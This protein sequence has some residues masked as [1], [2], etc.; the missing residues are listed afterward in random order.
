MEI[1]TPFLAQPRQS[2]CFQAIQRCFMSALMMLLFAFISGMLQTPNNTIPQNELNSYVI[3]RTPF[4][5]ILIDVRK[6]GEIHAV[7]GSKTQTFD[8]G[9]VGTCRSAGCKPY[10]F[11]WPD[12]FKKITKK[13]PKDMTVFVYCQDGKRSAKASAYL[14]KAGFAKAYNVGGIKTWTGSIVPPSEI[15]PVSKF[16][17]PSSYKLPE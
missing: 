7:I 11:A 9:M 4:D 8:C 6:A 1:Y 16:P 2:C 13:L 10:N 15:M 17:Q 14:Q 5:F 3:D 12:E